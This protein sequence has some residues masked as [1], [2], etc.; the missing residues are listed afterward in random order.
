M[1]P[2]PRDPRP[3]HDMAET[4]TPNCLTAIV[5]VGKA[6]RPPQN[7]SCALASGLMATRPLVPLAKFIIGFHPLV[8]NLRGAGIN[9]APVKMK[10]YLELR[11]WIWA[12][13][14]N[15]T[16]RAHAQP[17]EPSGIRLQQDSQQNSRRH[18]TTVSVASWSCPC[19]D[20]KYFH[21]A[22]TQLQCK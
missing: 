18:C 16:P 22:K 21:Q 3:Q 19:P 11:M 12:G 2:Q 9:R 13:F 14:C 1:S 10:N 5:T 4:H 17:S 6:Q 8:P 20:L 15:T 7:T